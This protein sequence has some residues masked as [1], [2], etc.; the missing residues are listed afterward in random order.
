MILSGLLC[1]SFL[2]ILVLLQ[3]E[4]RSHQITGKTEAQLMAGLQTLAMDGVALAALE[5]PMVCDDCNGLDPWTLVGGWRG[6]HRMQENSRLLLALAIQAQTWARP[7]SAKALHEMR[8]E[9]QTIRHAM[10][11]SQ[12]DRILYWK[13]KPNSLRAHTAAYAYY[14]MTESLLN[15]YRHSPSRLYT[16]LEETLW[17]GHTPILRVAPA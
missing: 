8:R 12:L 7:S 11:L 2:L 13:P 4:R 16:H 1:G 14:R 6:I 9:L 3:A 15:L 17:P 5:Y 10:L